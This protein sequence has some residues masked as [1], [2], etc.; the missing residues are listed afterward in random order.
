MLLLKT[1]ETW[2]SKPDL[3]RTKPDLAS[4][5]P[6]LASIKPDL[7]RNPDLA[8]IK[9]RSSVT[10]LKAAKIKLLNPETKSKKA[11]IVEIED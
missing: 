7:A 9:K 8:N 1:A 5:K 6:D 10:Y 2:H 4:T 11:R 3:A